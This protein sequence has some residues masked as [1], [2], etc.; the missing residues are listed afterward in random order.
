MMYVMVG[1][2]GAG[3]TARARQLE[4]ERKALRLTPDEWMIPLFAA[5]DVD[6]KRDVLEGR[7]V[8]LAIRVLRL[9]VSVILDFGVWGKDERSA[10]RALAAEA[11]A[12][13]ELVYLAVRPAEQRRRVDARLAAAP[14]STFEMSPDDLDRFSRLFQVPD[15]DELTSSEVD[16]PPAGYSTWKHWASTRWPTSTS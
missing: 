5:S 10:L 8:W 16:P 7:L 14:E 12:D 11:G 3:K 6:G 4:A 1:L 13:C 9:G 2:P 15:R